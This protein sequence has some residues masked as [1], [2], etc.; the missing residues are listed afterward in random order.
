[1]DLP[2]LREHGS[3]YHEH[4]PEKDHL[5]SYSDFTLWARQANLIDAA[6]E[7]ALN[8]QAAIPRRRRRL[9]W[10]GLEACAMPCTGCSRR[11]APAFLSARQIWIRSMSRSRRQWDS[12]RLVLTEKGF[13]WGWPAFPDELESPLWPVAKSAA[14]LTYFG[15]IREGERMRQRQVQL[16]LHR[17]QQESQP[18][19]V[20]YERL[21]QQREGPKALREEACEREQIITRRKCN[22]SHPEFWGGSCFLN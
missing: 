22:K 11:P 14:D 6:Q 7:H 19:V 8:E 1:M 5:D 18:P 21:R 2:E 17:H 15:E 16:D 9:C 10:P 4:A 3:N 12:G 20:R 13:E